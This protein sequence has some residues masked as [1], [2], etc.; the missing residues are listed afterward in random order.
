MVGHR[1][2]RGLSSL[3]GA[4]HPARPRAAG[5]GPGPPVR[6]P[7]AALAQ[8]P[9]RARAQGGE[10]RGRL[11]AP[12]EP[13]ALRLH[14]RREHG[15]GPERGRAARRRR[16]GAARQGPRQPRR[17][18]APARRVDGH[19][20]GAGGG[21]RRARDRG[22]GRGRARRRRRPFG[23]RLG[24]EQPALCVAAALGGE[25]DRRRAE[26]DLLAGLPRA[27]LGG[28]LDTG[29]RPVAHRAALVLQCGHAPHRAAARG[30]QARVPLGRRHGRGRQRGGRPHPRD[31]ECAHRLHDQLRQGAGPST[32]RGAR[33]RQLA[34]LGQ[35]RPA[36]HGRRRQRVLPGPARHPSGRERR[37]ARAQ[38]ARPRVCAVCQPADRKGLYG[39]ARRHGVDHLRKGGGA[40]PLRALGA[41]RPAAQRA[42]AGR[43]VRSRHQGRAR[44]PAHGGAGVQPSHLRAGADGA[45]GR[46]PRGLSLPAVHRRQHLPSGRAGRAGGARALRGDAGGQAA[47]LAVARARARASDLRGARAV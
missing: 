42:P 2:Q 21:A 47:A 24:P 38:H 17:R 15:R 22:R 32:R 34:P 43:E 10:R 5:Q 28:E 16:D 4:Q 29:R 23:E 19:P 35:P 12:V 14:G 1:P 30:G 9:R 18:R 36:R 7:A 40:A 33:A 3:P 37:R 25:R 45:R 26:Q 41:Q 39:G 46:V 11:G 27:A 44:R 31:A 6:P 13:A 20:P 8:Q